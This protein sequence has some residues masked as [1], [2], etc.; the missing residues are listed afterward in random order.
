M[1]IEAQF[2]SDRADSSEAVTTDSLNR[3]VTNTAPI[4]GVG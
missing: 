1:T 2:S 4:L 3:N